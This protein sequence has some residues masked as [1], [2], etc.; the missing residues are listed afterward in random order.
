MEAKKQ[1]RAEIANRKRVRTLT[2]LQDKIDMIKVKDEEGGVNLLKLMDWERFKEEFLEREVPTKKPL[3]IGSEK[4]GKW[5][6]NDQDFEVGA[7][8]VRIV[9][10]TKRRL[11]AVVKDKLNIRVKTVEMYM[12]VIR[13]EG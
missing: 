8:P 1:Q 5:Q 10:E 2:P 12:R 11:D 4:K 9:E 6:R 3:F 13:R 7:I